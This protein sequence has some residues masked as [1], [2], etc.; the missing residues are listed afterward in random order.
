[1]L[2]A[3]TLLCA[4]RPGTGHGGGSRHGRRFPSWKAM[5][6]PRS[7]FGVLV[8]RNL[9]GTGSLGFRLRPRHSPSNKA[10]R[11]GPRTA[12][13]RGPRRPPAGY[14]LPPAPAR[15]GARAPGAPPAGRPGHAGVCPR[16]LSLPLMSFRARTQRTTHAHARVAHLQAGGGGDGGRPRAKGQG[17]ALR[18]GCHYEPRL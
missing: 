12:G 10:R 9:G 1:M 8:E 18:R 6:R 7:F 17:H 4:P 15:P 13:A 3:T 14:R 2:P 16:H 5:P 11:R